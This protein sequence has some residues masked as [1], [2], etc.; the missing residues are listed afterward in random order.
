MDDYGPVHG[1]EVELGASLD[2][3]CSNDGG[4]AAAQ[5]IVADEDVVGVVGT[6]CSGA[7]VAAAR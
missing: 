1:F 4:Q 3:L 7:A 6:S 5:Q 2:D